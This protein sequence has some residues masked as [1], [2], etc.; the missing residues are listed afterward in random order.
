MLQA[1]YIAGQLFVA[2]NPTLYQCSFVLDKPIAY[3][4]IFGFKRVYDYNY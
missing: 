2:G 1:N 4:N 3:F